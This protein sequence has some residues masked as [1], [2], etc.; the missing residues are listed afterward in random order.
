[1]RRL[2]AMLALFLCAPAAPAAAQSFMPAQSA[3]DFGNSIGVN[4]RLTYTT[5]SY[6]DWPTIKARLIELGV[7][8]LNDSICPTC[9]YQ[10]DHLNQLAAL[11]IHSNLGVG[12]LN[13]TP[14]QLAT[15]LHGLRDTVRGSVI[16]IASINEPDIS[17][18][19][20]W[21]AKTRAFQ[22]ELYAQVK[23]DPS[24]R[25][26]PVL[27]PS[28]VNR[29][30]R[31]M[32]GDLSAYLDRGNIHPYPGGTPPLR[33]LADEQQLMSAVSGSKRL[34]ATET[35]YHTDLS[36]TG[37]HRPASETAKAIYTPRI[38]LEAFRFG[39]E[40]TYLYQ[41]ADLWSPAQAQ[42][43]GVA[44]SENSFGL[45][46]WDLSR[47][48]A[49]YS[50][51]NLLRVVQGDSAQ[52][53]DPHGLHVAVENAGPDVRSLLLE[54]ADGSYALVLWRDV[55]VWDR[56]AL[57]DLAPLADHVDVQLGDRITVARRFD[58]VGSDQETD[59]WSD[60]KRIGVGLEGAPVVLRLVPRGASDN[61]G[62]KNVKG[63][64]AGGV[65]K[66]CASRSRCCQA[67][68]ARKHGH[69]AKKKKRHRRRHRHVAR[70][71]ATWKAMPCVSGRRPR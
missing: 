55:S 29:D 11:G 48:P 16:S 49:F 42:A 61:G 47:K 1:M 22:K 54:A 65:L 38:A 36:F 69:R 58:P 26:L 66:A 35:G 5:S 31:A 18:D 57:L 59:H 39:V 44:P 34:V 27:G 19:P 43:Y 53:D 40:R 51:R 12:T 20:N 2:A 63:L 6:K 68:G 9:T 14:A 60:P 56:T 4:V 13:S 28:L 30:S 15:L 64:H 37:P 25:S 33:N 71:R 45:L 24:L 67:H 23:A 41:F 50:M 62:G 17:G 52:V 3:R 8:N 7:R 10:V 32:L 46:R 21:V 70:G